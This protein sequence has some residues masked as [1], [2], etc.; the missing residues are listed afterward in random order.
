MLKSVFSLLYLLTVNYP[1]LLKWLKMLTSDDVSRLLKK[2]QNFMAAE[3]FIF[4]FEVSVI[5]FSIKIKYMLVFPII[6]FLT[7]NL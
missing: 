5:P 4:S 3:A 1:P 7:N 2:Q 6:L